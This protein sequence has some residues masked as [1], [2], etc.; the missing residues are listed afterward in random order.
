MRACAPTRPSST[1]TDD[2][3][4]RSSRRRPSCSSSRRARAATATASG[5][6]YGEPLLYRHGPVGIG[7][8]VQT[9][10]RD[11]R[12]SQG[13]RNA[14]RPSPRP[15]SR[16]ERVGHQVRR[17]RERLAVRDGDG[18]DGAEDGLGLG[19]RA[20]SGGAPGGTRRA[21]QRPRPRRPAGRRRRGGAAGPRGCGRPGGGRAAGRRRRRKS[22]RPRALRPPS[23][24]R[25]RGTAC[26]RARGK[27]GVERLASRLGGRVGV[28]ARTRPAPAP[29]SGGEGQAGT[30]MGAGVGGECRDAAAPE[31]T[32]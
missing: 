27:G 25:R 23:G 17:R 26:R 20:C 28:R 5:P 21:R 6:T 4:R 24:R 19:R 32:R 8:L 30:R 3:P 9:L 16:L 7:D 12:C 15:G 31:S 29:P 2:G 14:G 22:G 11:G 1:P 10:G 13:G 18:A